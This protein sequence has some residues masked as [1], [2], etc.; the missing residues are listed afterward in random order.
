[1]TACMHCAT[2]LIRA[3]LLQVDA[4]I[5]TFTLE[6]TIKEMHHRSKHSASDRATCSDLIKSHLSKVNASATPTAACK[7]P[8]WPAPVDKIH[9]W[10]TVGIDAIAGEGVLEGGESMGRVIQVTELMPDQL[11]WAKRLKNGVLELRLQLGQTREHHSVSFLI[12][13]KDHVNSQILSLAHAAFHRRLLR[14]DH[15]SLYRASPRGK[16]V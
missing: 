15:I 8:P 7:L 14:H 5:D 16:K 1:M 13:R 3:Y 12:H 6:Y 4:I 10:N 9:T 11:S 2:H